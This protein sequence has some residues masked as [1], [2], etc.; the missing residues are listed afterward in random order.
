MDKYTGRQAAALLAFAW[1]LAFAG[2]AHAQ[3]VISQVYGGGGN[4]GAPFENDYIELHNNGAAAVSLDGW[5]VQYASSAGTTW[6]R[7]NLVGSI[8]PGGYYLVQQAKGANAS[9]PLPTPDASGNIAMSATAGKV[10][11]VDN[12]VTLSGACPTGNVDFVGF[13]T[14]ANCAEGAAPTATLSATTAA[15]R[16]D[17][18]CADTNVNASDFA[19]TAPVPRNSASPVAGCGGGGLAVLDIDDTENDERVETV[20]FQ[21]VLSQPAGPG[22]VSVDYT[23]VDGTAT[24]GSDYT[25][26]SGTI[27]L[28]EGVASLFLQVPVSDDAIAEDDE[29]FFVDFSNIRGAVLGNGR[30]TATLVDDDYVVTAIHAIQG[31]GATSPL[32]GQ[33]LHARGIVTGRKSN[34]FFLQTPDAEADADPMTS[35]GVF[36]FTRSAP[37]ADVA[38]GN[39]VVVRGRVEEFIPSGADPGQTPLTEIA[40]TRVTLESMPPV[41]W[42]GLLPTPVALSA[43]FPDPAGPLDQLERVEGMRVAIAAAT[44]VAPTQ[45]SKDERN[46]TGT[47]NGILHVV[48]DGVARPFRE[49][50]IALPDPVPGGERPEIPRWDFS[51]ELITLNSS[52]LGG[53]RWDLPFDTRISDLTG[54]LDYGFRRYT[55]LRDPLVL[56][57]IQA[58]PRSQPRPAVT[59]DALGSVSVAA[60]NLERFF[61]NVDDP[62]QAQEPILTADAYQ[63][64]LRKA[65]LGVRDYLHS[66]DILGVIEVENL[67]V[68]QNLADRI[69]QDA[70]AAGQPDPRYRAHL[71]E[72]NDIGGID[73]GFLLKG[74]DIAP[75]VAR[76]EALALSQIGKDAMWIEPSG[77]SSLLNDRPPLQL[78]A[79]VHLDDGRVFPLSVVL[80]HQRSLIGAETDDAAGDRIRRKRQRQAEFLATSLAQLQSETPE[81]H[82]VV[83]GD[84]N[85]FEF[86]D[87]LVDAMNVVTGTPG[88]DAATVVPGDG[89]D[90][91]DPDLVD[92]GSLEMASERYSYVFDGNAQTLDHVLVNEQLVVDT[93]HVV[94]SHARINADFPETNRNDANS[95][96]RLADHDPVRVDLVPR[97]RADLGV[98][99]VATSTEVRVGQALG[100]SA[101]LV[102]HGPDRADAPA[103][104]FAVDAELP[105]LT[106]A[107]SSGLWSCDAAQVEAGRTTIACTTAQWNNG[108]SVS[109]AVSAT[110]S[111]ALAG[112]P[113]ALAV[114][115]QAQSLDPV[116]GNDTATATIQVY[117]VADL[118]VGVVGPLAHLRSGTVGRYVVGI[119]NVGPD[120]ATQPHLTLQG[121]AP[122]A[123]VSIDAPHGW[124]CDV[125]DGGQGFVADCTRQSL[126]ARSLQHLGFSI[127]APPRQGDG[128]LTVQARIGAS[129]RDPHSSNDSAVH[130]V[131]L[132]GRPH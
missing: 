119:V 11:L 52:G 87:G 85:A 46:A 116:P 68:L 127:V 109:F 132:I 106:V 12:T 98:T 21:L 126:S 56:N 39:T 41:V 84:F 55:I 40:A 108:E 80:V 33:T 71:L 43:T 131:R 31:N 47:S 122:A 79:R 74:A 6:Q 97:R 20:L 129:V 115:S 123:N 111:A 67:A 75:G 15:V 121:D 83:L 59:L 14:A 99:A 66:P 96:S 88:A 22:G 69:N 89:L 58:G 49:P 51:P 113:L 77:A 100:F 92:L 95:P 45:G 73:V 57:L 17:N 8:A 27:T 61:D 78:D 19:I 93:S 110:A 44:V 2:T 18:G 105:S 29:T 94:H 10:A 72:G 25:A 76:V 4:G 34:G 30:A 23:T 125:Q 130:R 1:G 50:G 60:Y 48:V 101:T 65:S 82:L 42:P 26:T 114:A 70:V 102:N 103:I 128:L 64:R 81:R 117:A 13:G 91:I 54:P 62:A 32:V 120:I 35:Q 16:G 53:T 3:V 107:P 104:G 7:T 9:T 86:N 90:L 118:A 124:N 36:V 112:K 63:R 24:A 38:V 5:S 37:P 28:P